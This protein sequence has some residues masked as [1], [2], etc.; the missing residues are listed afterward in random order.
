M[1]GKENLIKRSILRKRFDFKEFVFYL[2][3][4]QEENNNLNI[5]QKYVCADG[6]K[7]GEKIKRIRAR[8][9]DLNDQQIDTLNRL[10]FVW[11]AKSFDFKEFM[12]HLVDYK[13]T[14]GDLKVP[15]PGNTTKGYICSDGYRL[16]AK[17]HNIRQNLL[18]I[19]DQQRA[20]L[21]KIGFIFKARSYDFD[22]FCFHLRQYKQQFKNTKVP[23]YYVCLDGYPLGDKVH[24]IR[25]RRAKLTKQQLDELALIGFVW[26]IKKNTSHL[27]KQFDFDVFYNKLAEFKAGCGN[28]FVDYEHSIDGYRLGFFVRNIR[29]HCIKLTQNQIEKLQSLGFVFDTSD[30][31]QNK[32]N[33]PLIRRMINGDSLARNYYINKF[34]PLIEV[35]AKK[36]SEFANLTD[37]INIGYD[38]VEYAL[39]KVNYLKEKQLYVYVSKVI[40]GNIFRFIK[41]KSRISS[42]SDI[43]P[44]SERLTIEDTMA[45]ETFRPDIEVENKTFNK[46]LIT[47]AKQLLSAGE[48]K[49]ISLYFGFNYDA[50]EYSISQLAQKYNT[51]PKKV[52]SALKRIFYK[53]KQNM[54]KEEWFILN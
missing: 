26:R 4:Y 52:E 6:Y 24:Y 33:V 36:Y 16:G 30:F 23:T 10:G 22:D 9:I 20:E 15:L 34:M 17:V 19:S 31:Y 28:C 37:L 1:K 42:L 49:L 54:P 44:D 32:P 27:I 29:N 21:I 5:P 41:E 43:L 25:T 46:Q 45:D 47:K 51:T 40:N 18:K 39:N 53:L 3:K 38:S 2:Q 8:R 48:Y 11:D 12:Q 50:T 13:N 14:Y 35:V 7:L